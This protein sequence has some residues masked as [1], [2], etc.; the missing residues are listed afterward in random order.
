MDAVRIVNSLV[1]GLTAFFQTIGEF[2]LFC[3]R[4]VGECFR[5]PLEIEETSIQVFEIG[6]RSTAL[7]VV[8]GFAIGVALAMQTRASMQQFGAESLVPEA[9]SFGLFKDVG[10]LVTALLVSG[11]AGAGIGAQLAGMRV[12]EQIDALESLA[13]DSFKYLVVTRI[14]ACVIALPILTTFLDFSGLAGG[15]ISELSASHMPL[16]LYMN[17]A[18]SP[19]GWSDYIPSTLKTLVFGFIIGTISSFLGYTA[20]EGATGIG[21]AS[22]RSVVFSSLLVIL[23][24]VVLVKMILVWFQ[25]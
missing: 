4:V 19:L 16:R 24:D 13:V 15:W 18:L 6:W 11:R 22:T 1:D 20:S 14:V 9:V 8:A 3:F 23:S 10:P 17:D 21:R 2:G 7:I 25:G 5:R 12:T